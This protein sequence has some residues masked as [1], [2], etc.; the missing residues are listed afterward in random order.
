MTSDLFIGMSQSITAVSYA[1]PRFVAIF[2]VLPLFSRQLIPLPLRGALILCLAVMVSPLMW[3][4]AAESRSGLVVFA[5]VAKEFVVGLL[6]GC[7]VAIPLWAVETMGDLIDSQRGAAI[8]DTMN[9][10]TGNDSSPLAQ[11]FSQAM[12]VFFLL[13]GG[14]ALLLGVI[15]DS[16]RLWPVF[17]W[18]PSLDAGGAVTVLG[19]LDSYMSLAVL[20]AAPVLF[21]MLLAE[22]GLALLSR[23]VPQ[24]QVFFLA[25]P[26]KSALAML[27]LALYA[28]ILFD[29]LDQRVAEQV[30]GVTS[31]LSGLLG[32]GSR[33]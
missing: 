9:V 11:L 22:V 14:F 24:L 25:M 8:A 29:H 17:G 18:W 3:A 26:I 20:L 16:F 2:S 12:Q 4:G 21:A 7:V 28:V 30:S 23:Y 5:I 31:V 13:A 15:Y 27:M 10:I 19:W 1:V 33:P 6:L 32:G